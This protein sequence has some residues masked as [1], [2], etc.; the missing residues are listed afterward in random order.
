VTAFFWNW[1]ASELRSVYAERD[2]ERNL[3][4]FAKK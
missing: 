4:A 2:R 1:S 3:A